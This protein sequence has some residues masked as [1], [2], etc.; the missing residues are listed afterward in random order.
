MIF[1]MNDTVLDVDMRALAPPM[2]AGRFRALSLAFVLK[3]G[4]ELYAERPL[5]QRDEPER[6]KRL[7]A[8][9]VCK[10]PKVN[11]ALFAAPRAACRPD[12]VASRLA[13][14]GV[15][16][17]ANLQVKQAQD[18]LTPFVADSEVWRRMAA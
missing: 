17:L 12:E 7:A 14:V 5:L 8:L 18:A 9:I 1:L 13:E 3:L 6:A 10:A 16:V 2:A 11:A 4:R 15:E